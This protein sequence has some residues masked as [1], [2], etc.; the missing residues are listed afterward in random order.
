MQFCCLSVCQ[1]PTQELY[2]WKRLSKWSIQ[3]PR[4]LSVSGA[5]RRQIEGMIPLNK[6]LATSSSSLLM[7]TS[8]ARACTQGHNDFNIKYKLGTQRL[9]HQIQ[10]WGTMTSTSNTNFQRVGPLLKKHI[11]L[12]HAYASQQYMCKRAEHSVSVWLLTRGWTGMLYVCVPFV[13][14]KELL[15]QSVCECMVIFMTCVILQTAAA[16]AH[17][18]WAGLNLSHTLHFGFIQAAKGSG[19]H[20][21]VSAPEQETE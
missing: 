7:P 20:V 18:V 16:A 11:R 1:I 13:P 15:P 9:Q 8:P 6:D 14:R 12:C 21:S 17:Q 10:T 4:D 5:R 3:L 2:C 19:M